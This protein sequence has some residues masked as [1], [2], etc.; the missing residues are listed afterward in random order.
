MEAL[1]RVKLGATRPIRTR[2]SGDSSLAIDDMTLIA[3]PVE[4][5]S[6]EKMVGGMMTVH[7]PRMGIVMIAAPLPTV[8]KS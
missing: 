6:S 4:Q 1:Q 5:W 8:E 7:T 3:M 2:W